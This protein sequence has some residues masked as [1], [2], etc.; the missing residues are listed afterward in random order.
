MGL[1]G[2]FCH[3]DGL[4]CSLNV[5]TWSGAERREST[6][7]GWMVKIAQTNKWMHYYDNG[8]SAYKLLLSHQHVEFNY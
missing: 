5:G 3:G 4:V 8:D 2:I 1:A 7:R 6:V